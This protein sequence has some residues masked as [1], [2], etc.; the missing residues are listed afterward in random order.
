MK[1]AEA[2]AR[3]NLKF[4]VPSLYLRGPVAQLG[5]GI[6]HLKERQKGYANTLAE[7]HNL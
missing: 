6:V 5:L 4:T 3:E 2:A 7:A 1:A